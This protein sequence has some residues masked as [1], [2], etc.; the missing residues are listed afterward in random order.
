MPLRAARP[1]CKIAF[2]S[3][4]PPGA[5]ARSNERP[6]GNGQKALAVWIRAFGGDVRVA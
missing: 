6:K 5:S 2:V 1:D 3:I 4:A